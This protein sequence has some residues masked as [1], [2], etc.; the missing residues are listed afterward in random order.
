MLKIIKTFV[1]ATFSLLLL[2][3]IPSVN[4]RVIQGILNIATPSDLKIRIKGVKGIFPFNLSIDKVKL[5]DSSEVWLEIQNLS[6]DWR[7]VDILYGN[8]HF[9]DIHAGKI[10]Y[11][12]NPNMKSTDDPLTLPRIN[13]DALKV[14]VVEIPIIYQGG[15]SLKGM[16]KSPEKRHHYV[17]LDLG[18]NTD[19]AETETII[20]EQKGIDY[21]L[22]S[23]VN[24]PLSSFLSLSPALLSK[25]EGNLKIRLDLSGQTTFKGVYGSASVDLSNF[26]SPDARVNN[27]LA[28]NSEFNFVGQ[29]NSAS[30]KA[31]QLTLKLKDRVILL[32]IDGTEQECAITGFL[33]SPSYAGQ[34]TGNVKDDLVALHLLGTGGHLK[35][36]YNQRNQTIPSF[37]SD[38]KQIAHLS[39]FFFH[40]F[41]G[42]VSVSGGWDERLKKVTL[43]AKNVST[44]GRSA[45]L[46]SVDGDLYAEK[47]RYKAEIKAETT[48]VKMKI[49]GFSDLEL[50]NFVVDELYMRP[51]YDKSR[52]IEL[53]KPIVIKAIDNTYR[54]QDTE[55]QLMEGGLRSKDLILSLQPKGELFLTDF[56]ARI[57]N[58][59]IEGTQW[60]GT[61]DGRMILG[62]D[63]LYDAQFKLKD[64]GL[65]SGERKKEKLINLGFTVR[66]NHSDIH[67]QLTYS[68]N[69]DS[70]LVGDFVAQ[71]DKFFPEENTSVLTSL[72]GIINLSA[73]N[74]LIW[75]GDRFKGK[76][77]VALKGKGTLISPNVQGTMSL[78]DGLYENGTI[79]TLLRE[80]KA[81]LGILGQSLV[82]RSFEGKD[83]DKGSFGMTGKVTF[84]ELSAPVLNL[85]L[86]LQKVIVANTH[87]AIVVTSGKLS[88]RTK[89][90]HHH[91]IQ[92][93]VHVNSALI[94]LNQVSSE[95]K[96]IRTFRTEEELHRKQAKKATELLTQ[97]DVKIDIPKKLYV[98]GFGLRSEWKG[99]MTV[100]GPLNMP[101]ISG[102]VNSLSG[103]LDISSKKLVLAPSS[104]TFETKHGQIMPVLDVT[105][106]KVVRE[107][108][109]FIS[110]KGHVDEPKIDFTSIPAQSTENVIALILFDK[111]INEVTAAQSLQLA[112]TLAAVKAGKFSGGA[113]DSLNQLLGV[114]DISLNK[115]EAIDGSDESNSHY[116]VAVGKQLTEKIFVG[117]EQGLQ[118]D[119]GSKV[120]AKVDVTKNTKVEAEVGTQNTALG[121]GLE[122]RY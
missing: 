88:A 53:K 8:I 37:Q 68:D 91:M 63:T 74:T 75:W 98:Q 87:E 65:E 60:R 13:I 102:G 7:G 44:N 51:I 52:L 40:P 43:R 42:E 41:W 71:T 1:I 17:K 79:G 58:S 66:H 120:K 116:S 33:K 38:F 103:R 108:E 111:P 97:L 76:L 35:V 105:A 90:P 93:D 117:L 110:V 3:Q 70:K 67:A 16:M 28:G 109:A 114:D 56:D 24:R 22:K 32:N 14:D 23:T 95:P 59:F 100:V 115:Q 72:T 45:L 12:R 27:I 2:L 112:T 89:K 10:I 69:L 64:F 82:V 20:Y 19:Y 29:V 21:T 122:F 78:K 73:L 57:L 54:V 48:D 81:E 9:A 85:D 94:N 104:V 18:F 6:F 15:F 25:T 101:N 119:V 92:G 107:Y 39:E 96:T 5:K 118:Q 80:I 46:S 61:L 62:K 77:T 106:K 55:I 99:N 86:V 11:F 30:S 49:A 31:A 83:Y 26:S 34:I 36:S 121:Y 47:D 4:T 50:H 113:L 84:P